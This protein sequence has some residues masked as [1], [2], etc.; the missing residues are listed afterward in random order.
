MAKVGLKKLATTTLKIAV[1]AA[2]VFYLIHSID[3]EEEEL[4]L[5]ALQ[6]AN[7]GIL[8][9]AFLLFNL[10]KILSSVRLNKYFKCISVVLDERFNL[11]L[12]YLGM[13]YNLFLPGGIGGDGYKVYY[14]NREHGGSVKK[15]V[16]ATILDRLSGVV[17]LGFLALIL[18][19]VSSVDQIVPGQNLL[20]IS[21]AIASFP[22][23]WLIHNRFFKDF[24]PEF[25][26]AL[27][28]GFGVQLSQLVCAA[29]ILWSIDAPGSYF[30][31]MTLFLVSSVVAVLPFT[32]GGIGARE[33]VML[34]GVAF[35]ATL[36]G[37]A[38]MALAFSILFFV[39]TA[40]SSLIGIYF[41]IRLK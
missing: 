1:S 14:L 34:K 6:T 19:I 12:Y 20:L 21:L 22:L 18:A 41:T 8:L 32:I 24:N 33:L 28:M 10:S 30:D 38:P 7:W 35:F 2:A 17:V 39:I 23:F 29:L 40:V 37:A 4:I 26:R 9:L 3:S 16:A 31:Y 25:I 15:L 5:D 11:K 36:H 27:I 13:F